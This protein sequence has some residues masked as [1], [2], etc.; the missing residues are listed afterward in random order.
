MTR[1]LGATLLLA[2]GLSAG[3]LRPGTAAP[4]DPPSE[5]VWEG[6]LKI[7]TGQTVRIVFHVE[8]AAGGALKATFDSPDQGA[9]GLKVDTATIDEEKVVFDMTGLASKFSGKLNKEKT[10]AVGNWE[11]GGAAL[12]LTLVKKAK[13]SPDPDAIVGKEQLW[14]GKLAVGAGLSLRLVVH[15]GKNAAGK[16]VATMDSPDQGSKGIKASSVTTDA[17]TLK[18]E[19]KAIGGKFEG[20]L[21]KDGKEATGTW[22]QGGGTIPLTLR[23]TDKVAELRRPQTPKAPFAYETEDVSYPNKAG[24]VSLAGT[25]TKPKGAGPFPAVIMISGSGAQDRDE[26]LFE[27]KPFLVIADDL[28]RRGVAVLRV[29]D[30]GVGGSTGDTAKSTSE[31]FAGDVLAGI[32]FLKTRPEID[33]KKIGLIG[34]SEGGVIAPMVAVKSTDVAFIVLLAGT[35]LPGDEILQLQGR[36]IGKALAKK[37][38]DAALESQ[39]AFQKRFLEVAKTEPDLKKAS[40]K[41]KEIYAEMK[42]A[43]PEKERKELGDVESMVTAQLDQLNGPWFRYFLTYDP[44]PT[45]AKVTCPVLALVGEKDLQ[46]PP[47]ENL[48]EITKALKVTKNGPTVVKELTGLNHLF[49]TCKTGSP[50]EYAEIEETIAPSALK[51]IGEWVEART[52]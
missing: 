5:T 18:F 15:V 35:G 50:G 12:P 48:T 27:H 3:F 45:L 25:L 4:A 51:E 43:M 40:A 42:A 1:S 13:A 17:E 8:K 46:V 37:G 29:D 19:I 14:E 52:R 21:S 33:R 41:M 31:D 22:T 23:K 34:H 7:G 24:G 47:R 39:L 44:R 49:Q 9:S 36:L 30:R 11:Q 6:K 32:A 28:T 26:T 20:K 16:L 10:E 2:L 38:E